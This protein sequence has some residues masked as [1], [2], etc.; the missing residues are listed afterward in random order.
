MTAE[1]IV[2]E[3][4]GNNYTIEDLKCIEK[5]SSRRT[6]TLAEKEF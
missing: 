1:K 4:Y 6:G 3:V 2:R 5:S